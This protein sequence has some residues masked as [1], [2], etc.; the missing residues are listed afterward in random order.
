MFS[1]LIKRNARAKVIQGSMITI[2]DCFRFAGILANISD[3]GFAIEHGLQVNVCSPSKQD[4]KRVLIE[5]RIVSCWSKPL[6][7]FHT[8]VFKMQFRLGDNRIREMEA[9][10]APFVA[11]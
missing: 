11:L 7:L 2:R 10:G 6:S 1:R 8:M 4:R 3:C 9:T 5:P